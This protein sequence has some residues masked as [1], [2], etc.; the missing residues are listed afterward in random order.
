[1]PVSGAAGRERLV[2]AP[3]PPA[4]EDIADVVAY[5]RGCGMD[6]A[7]VGAEWVWAD[8]VLPESELRTRAARK[9]ALK[10]AAGMAP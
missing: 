5:L 6:L 8:R 10:A 2:V 7:R 1:M 4:D 9:R 3:D